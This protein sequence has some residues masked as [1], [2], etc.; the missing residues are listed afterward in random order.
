[1]FHIPVKGLVKTSACAA[2]ALSAFAIQPVSAQQ[3]FLGELMYGGFNF[4][5]QG[6][7]PCNGQILLIS[8]YSAL[9]SLLGTNYGGN[10]TSNFALPDMQGRV[11]VGQGQGP[12]LS[13][14]YV[15]QIGGS[16]NETVL[17]SN[18]PSHTHSVSIS[19]AT[20]SASS[21]TASSA[22]P[23]GHALANTGR[24][25]AY[26]STAPDVTLGT[27]ITVTGVTGATGS[28]VPISTVPPYLTVSCNIAMQ[29]VF[30]P[31]N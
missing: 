1:M 22:V 14:Y 29:G 11:P 21:A 15:G 3:P 27:A 10:G 31:R 23:A 5:P 25:L 24:N 7:T 6:W 30:P 13:P 16:P 4:A 20:I 2:L 12:G 19:G 8:Q 17:I 28:N 18:M 9:F 26:N